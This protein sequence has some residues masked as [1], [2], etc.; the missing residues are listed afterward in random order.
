[1][2]S[3]IHQFRGSFTEFAC[4]LGKHLVLPSLEVQQ[5]FSPSLETAGVHMITI[6]IKTSTSSVFTYCRGDLC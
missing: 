6:R 4:K 3:G 2:Q 5:T 1:M